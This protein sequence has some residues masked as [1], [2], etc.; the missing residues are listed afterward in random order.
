MANQSLTPCLTFEDLLS[1]PERRRHRYIDAVGTTQEM[2][3]PYLDGLQVTLGDVVLHCKRVFEEV[4]S[5]T[6][7]HDGLFA[8]FNSTL[9]GQ[10]LTEWQAVYNAIP[11]GTALDLAQLEQSIKALIAAFAVDA[12]R[13]ALLQ[14]LRQGVPKKPKR[15]T[16]QVLVTLVQQLNNVADWLPGQMPILTDAEL[17][18]AYHDRMPSAWTERLAATGRTVPAEDLQSLRLYFS[19]QEALAKRL[20]DA[21]NARQ[22]RSAGRRRRRDDAVEDQQQGQQLRRRRRHKRE[23]R[24]TPAQGQR[25]AQAPEARHENAA[26]RATGIRIADNAPCPVHPGAGHTWGECRENAR[27]RA[28]N[29]NNNRNNAQGASG[30]QRRGRQQPPQRGEAQGHFVE[31][32]DGTMEQEDVSDLPGGPTEVS[33]ISDPAPMVLDEQEQLI[34]DEAAPSVAAAESFSALSLTDA[35]PPSVDSTG[36]PTPV[37]RIKPSQWAAKVPPAT[38]TPL[39]Q[40]SQ[41]GHYKPPSKPTVPRKQPPTPS[42]A[43]EKKTPPVAAPQPPLRDETPAPSE[44]GNGEYILPVFYFALFGTAVAMQETHHL[45]L[46]S[47]PDSFLEQSLDPY[48]ISMETTMF[49][50]T[51]LPQP[52]AGP[53]PSYQTITIRSCASSGSALTSAS[54]KEGLKW[55]GA[56]LSETTICMG[57]SVTAAVSQI[58]STSAIKPVGITALMSSTPPQPCKRSKGSTQRPNINNSTS[59]ATSNRTITVTPSK[60]SWTLLEPE[61]KNTSVDCFTTTTG[62]IPCCPTGHATTT[63]ILRRGPKHARTSSRKVSFHSKTQESIGTKSPPSSIISEKKQGTCSDSVPFARNPRRSSTS[64][65]CSKSTSQT[66]GQA[67][68]SPT[69]RSPLTQNRRQLPSLTHLTESELEG[70]CASILTETFPEVCVTDAVIPDPREHTELEP[71]ALQWRDPTSSTFSPSTQLVPI[72]LATVQQFSGVSAPTPLVVLFDS[73]SQLSFLKRSKVPKECEISTIA[74]PVRGLTGT[75]HLTEEVTLTGITLPEFST[76]KRIDSSLRCLLLDEH[77]EDSTYDMI[78]GLD[79]LC[80]VGIDILCRQKQLEWDEATMAFQ[81]RDTY[82]EPQANLHARLME[83]FAYGDEEDDPEGLGYKSTQAKYDTIDTDELAQAQKQLTPTQRTE[84]AHLFRKFPQLFDGE[85]R[86]Y[87]HR[88]YH[89]DLQDGAKPVHSRPYGVPLTQRDAFKRE[90][91]HL[92]KIG[93]LERSGASQWASGTFI[94]PKKDGRVRWISDFRALNKCIKRKTYPFTFLL[95]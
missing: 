46:F 43:A 65:T 33:E 12:D 42:A 38:A 27:N 77:Q 69:Q 22:S 88:Q 63:S 57:R 70:L 41:W 81:P 93:V 86:T 17:K 53:I 59:G 35:S 39:Q 49:P 85:L 30:G 91:D 36:R 15:I 71:T 56:S 62:T 16:V 28:N 45:D 40:Q 18:Q 82:K 26:G 66:A 89:L 14:Y 55:P 7:R 5:K 67:L 52:I 87:P 58:G 83:A 4:R 29:N 61:D 76:S 8:T 92:I 1:V 68:R 90:L 24:R 32:I 23:E 19:Q 80:A 31:T 6:F 75:S 9:N 25:Q 94:I 48:G 51:A 37:H 20:E 79:F 60:M 3:L 2:Y 10:A 34:I 47:F 21:N 64:T 50:S 73:G 13:H 11:D 84:L 54:A 78:L 95:P 44:T 74:Q 72:S